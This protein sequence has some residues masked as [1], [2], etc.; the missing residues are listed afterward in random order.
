MPAK[1]K[2]KKSKKEN[3]ASINIKLND[4]DKMV[5]EA[6]KGEKKKV[7]SSGGGCCG[8]FWVFGSALAMV[9]S[10]TQNSSIWWALLHGVLSWIYVIYKIVLLYI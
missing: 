5:K 3:S 9:I 4:V 8:G 2:S 7:C 6:V 10:Y 1:T